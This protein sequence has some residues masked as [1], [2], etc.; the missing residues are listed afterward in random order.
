[1]T[2][3]YY[4]VNIG[5][6]PAQSDTPTTNPNGYSPANVSAGTSAPST[7]FYLAVSQTNS[8][9]NLDLMN[10]MEAILDFINSRGLEAG[11]TFGTDISSP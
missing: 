2:T 9:S 3:Y 4:G 10:A 5:G 6:Y 1:M 8:P 11:G 7:D